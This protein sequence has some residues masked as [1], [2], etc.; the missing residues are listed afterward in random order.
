MSFNPE[1]AKKTKEVLF[2]R[3]IIQTNDPQIFFNNILVFK[4]QKLPPEVFYKKTC[5]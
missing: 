5:S 3:K 1:P 2:N 4:V